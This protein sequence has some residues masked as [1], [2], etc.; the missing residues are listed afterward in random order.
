M[1]ITTYEQSATSEQSA[2]YGKPRRDPTPRDYFRFYIGIP[3]MLGFIFSLVGTR[4]TN[5]MPYLDALVYLVLHMFV[6]WWTV[7]LGAAFA[8]FSFRSWRPP[9]P[10]LKRTGT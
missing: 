1:A 5:G 6:A 9:T 8:K 3:V 4:L 10:R 7:N 2:G